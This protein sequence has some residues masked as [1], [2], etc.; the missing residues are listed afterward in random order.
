[1]GV[2]LCGLVIGCSRDEPS[3]PPP[4]AGDKEVALPGATVM[5][6][7]GD[8]GVCGGS[9]DEATAR[10]VDSLLIVDSA[11]GVQRVVVTIGDN[12][13]ASGGVG[14]A[15]AFRRCF[16]PSWGTPRIMNVIRPSPGNHDYDTGSG[17]PYF[18]YFGERAGPP[19]KGYYS[20]DVGEWHV[21]SL[22]SELYFGRGSP[23]EARAQEDW[24]RRDLSSHR[25][26]CT[27]AYFHRPL[28]SSG[29]HSETR[30][31][32]PLWSILYDADADL[33]LNGHDHDYERFH[34]QTP[35][36]AADASRGITQIVVGTGGAALRGLRFPLAANS[37]SR[38]HGYYGILKLTL[39]TGEYRH[40]FLDTKGRVWDAG[41]GKCH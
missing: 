9:G 8:I 34:P 10:I 30:Q 29:R 11:A 21:I 33:I 18:E 31:M 15:N 40:A 14:P 27:M 39:G 38:V 16:A 17:E 2:A 3:T 13:Y 7:V 37:A 23:A 5:I 28:F 26:R 12:A 24:L 19:G 41:S 36:G 25:K 20:Y 35:A 32:R 22:N 6:G 1:L 4:G